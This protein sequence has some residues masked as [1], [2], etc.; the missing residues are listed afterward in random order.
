LPNPW[1]DSAFIIGLSWRGGDAGEVLGLSPVNISGVFSAGSFSLGSMPRGSFNVSQQAIP[2]Q[3]DFDQL[4][5][6]F[7]QQSALHSPSELHGYLCGQLAAGARLSLESWFQAAQQQIGIEDAPSAAL[8]ASLSVLYQVTLAQLEQ[9][10][11]DLQPL[12]PDEDSALAQR[13]ET[14]GLWCHGFLCGYA[15]A[16]GRAADKLGDDAR[17]GLQD[18]S[19]IAQI[20]V[21]EPDGEESESNFMEIHEYVRMVALLVFSEC[22]RSNNA[23][24]PIATLPTDAALH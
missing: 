11:F 16:N 7:V 10:G 13:A 15:L 8:R 19:Q 12:I 23:D 24:E 21:D 17:D 6:L 2:E 3:V 5:D 22:N 20:A 14:L 18:L 4:A 9:A 1:A